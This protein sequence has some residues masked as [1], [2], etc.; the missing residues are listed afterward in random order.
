ML[1]VHIRREVSSALVMMGI[2]E[3]ERPAEVKVIY[4]PTS[5]CYAFGH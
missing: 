5:L 2:K 4:V 3:M 1:R